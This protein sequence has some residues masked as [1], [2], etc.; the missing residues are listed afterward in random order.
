MAGLR[1]LN[2]RIKVV[3]GEPEVEEGGVGLAE[4]RRQGDEGA[5]QGLVLGGD[6]AEGLVGVGDEVDEVVAALCDRAGD[7]AAADE[8]VGEDPLVEVELLDQ[9]VGGDQR[10]AQEAVGLVGLLGASGVDGGRALDD[11]LEALALGG[12]EGVE[13]LV[14]VDG[15]GGVD[16]GDDGAVAQAGGV[17]GAGGERDVAVGDSGE[18]GLADHRLGAL[19]ELLVDGD[20]DLGLAVL[21]Q[22]DAV[23]GADRGAADQ[24]LVVLD[25][26]AAGLEDQVVVVAVV[27]A[28]EDEP[29]EGDDDQ[30]EGAD[31]S[32]A[33]EPA[34]L[35][36][37]GRG[38]G[39][40]PRL[41]RSTARSHEFSFRASS[42][43]PVP[44]TSPQLLPL[45]RA[46][47]RS[48]PSTR[49]PR[50]EIGRASAF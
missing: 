1:S 37:A 26:L 44:N 31:R 28:A 15:G 49:W 2:Q 39:A 36:C 8:E 50:T 43:V 4:G 45:R 42:P 20:G 34:G 48:Y 33:T 6:R 9:V 47:P 22:L 17:V 21:R 35:A 38:S 30:D 23:D 3:E 46:R 24:D 18:G 40:H 13:E 16:L 10:R 27:V 12:A 29:G 14:E 41:A 5:V 25:Q 32:D 19:V 7:A 11:V